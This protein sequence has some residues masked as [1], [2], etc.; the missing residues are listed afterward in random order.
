MNSA[1]LHGCVREMPEIP[2][3]LIWV[4]QKISSLRELRGSVVVIYVWNASTFASYDLPERMERL[5]DAYKDR[6]VQ[7]IGI[8]EPELHRERDV[9]IVKD[10]WKRHELH[11]A[12]AHDEK[13][14]VSRRFGQRSPL[15]FIVLGVDGCV[16]YEHA[17]DRM[18]A[19]LELAI[20]EALPR[21]SSEK[22]PALSYDS[23]FSG[24]HLYPSQADDYLGY[25]Q[26]H[27]EVSKDF[28]PQR[29]CAFTDSGKDRMALH[30][31]WSVREECCVHEVAT[32]GY[33]EYLRVRYRALGVAL[34]AES[35]KS[36][37]LE[38]TQ[39]KLPISHDFIGRDVVV[40]NDKTYIQVDRPR[41]YEIIKAPVYHEG[42][43]EILV[44]NADVSLYVVRYRTV[45]TVV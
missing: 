19:A 16:V 31:H 34:F 22:L 29:V 26:S 43:L 4:S 35:K 33:R 37:L 18:N 21:A 13:R 41:L 12:C 44:A 42:S 7:V 40:K 11:H 15:R 45:D 1:I 23:A 38:V 5:H 9:E 25:L 14:M 27:Y 8:H 30:G 20:Q 24:E 28:F 17:G 3:D 36:A 6:G 32:S 2:T 10:I 39:G